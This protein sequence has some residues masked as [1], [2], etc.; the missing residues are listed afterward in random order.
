MSHIALLTYD[1]GQGGT[2]RVACELASG[3]AR[4]GHRVTLV[5]CTSAG[6]IDTSLRAA[7]DPDVAYVALSH[8]KWKS[9]IGGQVGTFL[10]Y[11]RWIARE[12]PDIVMSTGNAISWFTGLGVL[13]Q[14]AARPALCI[15]VTN[16]VLRVGA[17]WLHNKLRAAIY[18]ALF[19]RA[20]AV[21]ML[22]EADAAQARVD[23]PRAAGRV[24]AVYNPY[25]ADRQSASAPHIVPGGPPWTILAVGRMSAQKNFARLIDAF[26]RAAPQQAQLHI[27]GDGPH[28]EALHQH[29]QRLAV[30]ERVHMPGFCDDVP[31]RMARA[32]LFVLSSDY[33]G[34]P[35]VVIEA[36]AANC[37]VI[38]T[39][40][41]P[42]VRELLDGLPG[43]RVCARDTDALAGAMGDW[44]AAPPPRGDVT[45]RAAL[46]TSA[47]AVRSHMGAMEMT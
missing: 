39:D 19:A 28:R 21:M 1:L 41:F 33:E 20:R 5:A 14:R 37:P 22:S 29:A 27:V 25:I 23:F 38:A 10:A 43:C 15:K 35:A 36:L 32:H 6:A 13:G 31:D 3:F 17:G 24:R 30:A 2:S 26:A 45:A 8:R 4:A 11:R 42:M 46:Y 47:S 18:G 7:L 12:R 9:R 16:P 34:L 44:F 40:C